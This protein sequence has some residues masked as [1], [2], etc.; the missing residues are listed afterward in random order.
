MG[1]V[2]GQIPRQWLNLSQART[3]SGLGR[4]ILRQLADEGE[5]IC[6]RTPGGHRR[7]NRESIDDYLSR[8]EAQALAIA[9]S[10]GL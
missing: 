10:L 8:G 4:D 9:R 7:W 3:Y 2:S 1:V 5:I 6:G